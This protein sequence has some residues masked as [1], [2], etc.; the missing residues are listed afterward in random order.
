MNERK[1]IISITPSSG[2]WTM[3]MGMTFE[4]LIECEQENTLDSEMKQQLEEYKRINP[5][6]YA[7]IMSSYAVSA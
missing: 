7:K 3:E 4:Y 1:G 5:A 6:F 2:I